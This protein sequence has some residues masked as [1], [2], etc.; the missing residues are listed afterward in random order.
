MLLVLAKTPLRKAIRSALRERG[1]PMTSGRP[2]SEDLFER[3]LDCD[4]LVYAPASNLLKGTLQPRP[5]PDRMRA[6]LRAANA[7][8]CSTVVVVVPDVP[9]YQSEIDVLQSSGKP[10][11]VVCAPPMVEEIGAQVAS[12]GAG[13]LW[14]PRG[15]SVRASDARDVARAV[16]RASETE[17]QGRIETVESRETDLATLFRHAAESVGGRV[18]VHPVWP[19]LHRVIRPVA[20]WLRRGEPRALSLASSLERHHAIEKGEHHV[21]GVQ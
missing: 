16:L 1:I 14:I 18:R 20:R 12:D 4:T 7:P 19:P 9:S 13:S 8:G 3:A 6:V 21:A 5:R 15:G 11:V 17:W 2:D 10:Y